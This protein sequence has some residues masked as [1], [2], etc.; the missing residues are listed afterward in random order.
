MKWTRAE[1]EF[2]ETARVARLATIAAGGGPHVV[3]ICPLFEKGLFYLGTDRETAKV[4]HICA[5]GRV[6]LVFDDYTEDWR[7]L[8]GVLVEGEARVVERRAFWSVRARLYRKYAQ[9]ETTAPLT[10]RDAIALEIKPRRKASWG[11]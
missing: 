6:A 4:R 8:R 1:R 9:Y 7:H 10:D 11:F 2:L 3:P 5:N